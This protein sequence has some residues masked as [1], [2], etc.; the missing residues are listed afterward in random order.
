MGTN[1]L[2]FAASLSIICGSVL[3]FFGERAVNR[4]SPRRS[5]GF[6]QHFGTTVLS[7]GFGFMLFYAS[8]FDFSD[9][10]AARFESFYRPLAYGVIVAGLILS[11]LGSI[12]LVGMWRTSRQ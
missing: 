3:W 11:V 4:D 5:T 7:I 6:V 10:G 12:L 8:L 1:E 9:A 2:L